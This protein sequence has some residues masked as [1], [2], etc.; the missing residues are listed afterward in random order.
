MD[1]ACAS[2]Q[3]GGPAAQEIDPRELGTATK[4]QGA[5]WHFASAEN[6]DLF[7]ASPE[8]YAPQYGGYCAYAVG[9][10]YTA[11]ITPEAW[12]VVGG[13]LY[14]NY[15]KGVK[16]RWESKRAEYIRTGDANWPGVL[17]K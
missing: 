2:I 4:Y 13:K 12:A 6:R 5:T 14:L 7:A 1:N 9:N 16:R 8:A 3:G 17:D 11:S 10:G 15:S